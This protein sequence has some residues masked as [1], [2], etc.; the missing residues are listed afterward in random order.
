M[1][2]I[3][4]FSFGSMQG[5]NTGVDV[6]ENTSD[7]LEFDV[8]VWLIIPSASVVEGHDQNVLDS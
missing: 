4:V 7:I 5:P 1:T 6:P 3:V 8:Q 2:I